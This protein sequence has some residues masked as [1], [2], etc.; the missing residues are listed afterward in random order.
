MAFPSKAVKTDKKA[1]PPLKHDPWNFDAPSY[2]N[3]NRVS[4]GGEYGVG[5]TQPVGHEG[6]PKETVDSLPQDNIVK[7]LI[8]HD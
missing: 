1:T 8:D 3:R 4:A 2:D 5:S 6:S 7:S